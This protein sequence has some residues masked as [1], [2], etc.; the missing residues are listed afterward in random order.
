MVQQPFLLRI[1]TTP[2]VA[3]FLLSLSFLAPLLILSLPLPLRLLPVQSSVREMGY[4]SSTSSM[5]TDNRSN[6]QDDFMLVS[7]NR[8]KTKQQHLYTN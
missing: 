4:N 7:T 3:P 6:T 8:R 5:T 1:H 2:S